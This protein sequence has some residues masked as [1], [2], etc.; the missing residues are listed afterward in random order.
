MNPQYAL[1]KSAESSDICASASVFWTAKWGLFFLLVLAYSITQSS[2][3]MYIALLVEI[4]SIIPIG[5]PRIIK[6]S[7]ECYIELVVVSL[8]MPDNY[9][10]VAVIALGGLLFVHGT[11]SRSGILAI[12]LAALYCSF[13]IILCSVPLNNIIVWCIYILPFPLIVFVFKR[14]LCH[15]AGIVLLQLKRLILLEFVSVVIYAVSHISTI[16]SYNDMDWVVGTMGAYQANTLMCVSAFSLLVFLGAL[17]HRS[18]GMIPWCIMSAL[19]TVSTSS[20]SFLAIFFMAAVVVFVASW[21]ASMRER[22]AF[23]IALVVAFAAFVAVSPAWIST[24]IYKMTDS[25]YAQNRFEKGIYYERT[26]V[27]IPSDQGLS[28]FVFGTGLG[29]Y[30][31]RAALTCAGGYI[32]IYDRYFS[33]YSSAERIRYLSD[34]DRKKGLASM[35]D[36]SIISAQGELGLVGLVA[37]NGMMLVL[38]VRSK[39]PYYRIAVLFFWGLLFVDNAMEYAK[40]YTMFAASMVAIRSFERVGKSDDVGDG[41]CA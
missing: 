20:V 10:I 12:A 31:S 30:S 11:I 27:D 16:L 26:F 13:N 23:V 33:P 39:D 4:A 8:M 19:L 1:T 15:F 3:I 5:R 9:C 35:A 14:L 6:E 41:P 32:D 18:K 36:S 34:Q 40:V 2:P 37:I 29:T 21:Q 38:F 17:K 28:S 24:E 22:A 7:A 25:T